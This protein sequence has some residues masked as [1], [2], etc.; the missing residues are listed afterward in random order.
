[1]CQVLASLLT[2]YL[3]GL[4]TATLVSPLSS[5][6]TVVLAENCVWVGCVS[7]YVCVCVGGGSNQCVLYICHLHDKLFMDQL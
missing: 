5:K 1:M 7:D 2:P 3:G 6:H 4:E